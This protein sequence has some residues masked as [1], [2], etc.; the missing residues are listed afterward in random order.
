MIKLIVLSFLLFVCLNFKAQYLWQIYPDTIIKW[1]Y[2]DGDEFNKNFVNKDKWFIGFP[3]GKNILT[4]DTYVVDSN[5]CLN[6]QIARFILKKEN[7]LVQLEPWQI[8]S[9]GFKKDRIILID[10][11]KFLF[12]YSGA[13]L[14]S[15][16]QFKYGYF[17]IKFKAPEGQGIW[18]A[19]WLY[20]GTPNNEI[21]FFE[22][23]GEEE[24]KIHVDIH[25]PDGC[26]NYKEF[27]NYRKSWGHWVSTNQ[28]LRENYNVVSGDWSPNFIKWYLNG[29]L[30][31]YSDHSFDMP[32]NLTLGTGIA[33]DKGA[34][35][36]GPNELT[37][38]PNYFDVDY[39]RV[40]KSDTL[41]DLNKIIQNLTINYDTVL[42]N[43][44]GDLKAEKAHKRLKYKPRSL[45]IKPLITVSIMQLSSNTYNIR[46]FGA[47]KKNS[48]KISITDITGRG[49]KS[50]MVSDILETLFLSEANKT[51]NLQIEVDGRIINEKIN[52]E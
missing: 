42:I 20:G 18:P 14:W 38:F 39:V 30:I 36:P 40:Y 19:F 43:K 16:K 46:V 10:K 8:D 47:T 22:L 5:I 37:P 17:E 26:S 11:N 51:Y 35:N 1:S 12:K 21:D 41:P 23:K 50:I 4:Q 7:N 6:N 24:K 52:F 25:C 49:V 2:S 44:I 32:M 45:K 29:N 27:L 33:K 3:W 34:F 28:K 31:A 15:K 9:V 13:L 48:V